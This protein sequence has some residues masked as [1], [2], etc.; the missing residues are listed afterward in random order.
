MDGLLLQI[1]CRC[2][3]VKQSTQFMIVELDDALWAIPPV[4]GNP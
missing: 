1:C 3:S 2:S 4:A